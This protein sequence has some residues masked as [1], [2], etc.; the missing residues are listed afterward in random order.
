MRRPTRRR[1]RA[2]ALAAVLAGGL[3]LELAGRQQGLHEPVIYEPT[4]YGYRVMPNQDLIRFE[5]RSSY[6]AQGLRSEAISIVPEE[7][8]LRVLCLGDSVTNGGA[9]TDQVDTYPYQLQALLKGRF[10]K[11]EVLNASAPGWAVSN[12]L[13][14]L[15]ANGT[16]GSHYVV[17]AL[18][19][20]DLFQERAPS[21]IVGSHQSFPGTRPHLAVQDV[22]QRYLVPMFL[23][24]VGL[25]SKAGADPGVADHNYSE[26]QAARNRAEV[27][28]IEGIVREQGG[29]LVVMFLDEPMPPHSVAIAHMATTA[30]FNEMSRS[31][32]P[33]LTLRAELAH[34]ERGE[35]FRD[36]VHPNPVGNRVIAGV[37]ARHISGA[38]SIPND[39]GHS[40]K[41]PVAVGR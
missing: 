5:N 19:T 27:L 14:W 31:S 18:S 41:V 25:S 24:T 35:L 39:A 7:G 4:A 40:S 12:E 32:V 37:I 8:T 21:L 15:R 9:I 23:E 20:H 34:F 33:V 26:A 1:A 11:V 13:G 38:A 16:F 6:N 29:R 36:A 28:L 2:W 22:L 30:M 10:G 3:A 17:I